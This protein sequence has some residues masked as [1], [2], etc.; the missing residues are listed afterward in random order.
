MLD[1][2]RG[3]DGGPGVIG[4]G[5]RKELPKLRA[6]EDLPVRGGVQG[7]GAGQT[8]LLTPARRCRSVSVCQNSSS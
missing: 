6:L 7:A 8:S 1:I 2:E 4:C 3:A 5:M